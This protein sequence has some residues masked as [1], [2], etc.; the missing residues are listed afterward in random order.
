MATF[1]PFMKWGTLQ[2][3][4]QRHFDVLKTLQYSFDQKYGKG[5]VLILMELDRETIPESEPV[6]NSILKRKVDKWNDAPDILKKTFQYLVGKSEFH[7]AIFYRDRTFVVA[8][9]GNGCGDWVRAQEVSCEINGCDISGF[10]ILA[11]QPPNNPNLKIHQIPLFRQIRKLSKDWGFDYDWLVGKI[12]TK[13]HSS[14]GVIAGVIVACPHKECDHSS[15]SK[16]SDD[17][18]WGYFIYQKESSRIHLL[19]IHI[20][21][22][23]QGKGL[24]QSLINLILQSYLRSE[25]TEIYLEAPRAKEGFYL[26]LGFAI[27]RLLPEEDL[28]EMYWADLATDLDLLVKLDLYHGIAC[29]HARILLIE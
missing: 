24:G 13:K 21:P 25:I 4:I 29:P 8:V 23:L 18:I 12:G 5:K 1:S 9:D 20:H 15:D 27:R 17:E 22:D 6:F 3:Y 2:T 19:A 26:S 10:H 11:V 7:V 14:S 28:V 16:F